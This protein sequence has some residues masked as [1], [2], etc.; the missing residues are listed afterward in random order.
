ME[1]FSSLDSSNVVVGLDI[2]T[3]KIA[4]I[5]GYRDEDG[6]IEVLGFGKS[7]SKGVEFGLIRNINKTVEGINLSKNAAIQRAGVDIL[8]VYSGIAGRHI[9]TVEYY[10]SLFRR[11]GKEE[12]IRQEEID[13]LQDDVEHVSVTP[14]ESI[15]GVIPQYFTIDDRRTTEPVGE[16]GEHLV[17]YYQIIT[18]N[19]TEIK[20]IIRC[21]D[22][23]DLKANEIILE[24][25]ASGLACLNAEEKRQGVALVDIGGGTT[26][27]AIFVDGNPVF[28]KVISIGGNMI[29]KDIAQVCKI[30]MDMAEKL[31]V[32]YGTCVPEK[33]NSNNLITIPQTHGREPIQINENY[34]AQIIHSR[35]QAEILNIVKTEIDRSGYSEQL[36]AGVVLT[37][38][39]S[40]LRNIKELCQYTLARPTRIG[41]P[42]V[43]FSRTLQNELKHPMYSTALGLLKYGIECSEKQRMSE[44]NEDSF[45]IRRRNKNKNK[46]FNKEKTV[47]SKPNKRPSSSDKKFSLIDAIQRF[48]DG[49]LE[50]TS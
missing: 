44:N 19:E 37:G 2:G 41:I 17:G 27:L 48:L 23:A 1:K 21:V 26:D 3:T 50:K 28:T 47:D 11:N 43:G 13:R 39:G 35:V 30:P 42:E 18:G 9:K 29:T 24:P 4:T 32:T 31:K 14:G 36:L 46:D 34:L 16:L 25:I 15:I 40:N 20:K 45:S 12:I 38:G 8:E 49:V 7:E 10:H 22:T 33:S 6:K 5:I